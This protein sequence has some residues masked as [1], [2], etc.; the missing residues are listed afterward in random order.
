MDLEAL[1]ALD[2]TGN[3]GWGPAICVFK[4]SPGRRGVERDLEVP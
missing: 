3:L 1:S 4:S 2:K